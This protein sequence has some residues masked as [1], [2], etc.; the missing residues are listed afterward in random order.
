MVSEPDIQ[1][2]TT[3]CG[4]NRIS[5]ALKAEKLSKILRVAAGCVR[6]LA[7]GHRI[8]FMEVTTVSETTISKSISNQ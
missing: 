2:G 3:G 5:S 6:I 7:S 8:L 1:V 4:M